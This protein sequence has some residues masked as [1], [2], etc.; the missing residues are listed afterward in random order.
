M[1]ICTTNFA[2]SAAVFAVALVCS[3]SATIAAE[4]GSLKGKFVYDGK[5][6]SESLVVTKDPE[7]CGKHELKD[8]TI[9]LGEN[10]ELQNAYVFLYVAPGKKVDIHPDYTKEEAKPRVLDNKG[11]RFEPHAM[12]LWTEHPLEI[13]N[14]DQGIG[15][16]TNASALRANRAFNDSV[17]NSDPLVKKFTK[18]EPLPSPVAC[19][20]HPWMKAT[21]LIR[22]NP[23]MA[24][25]GEDGSFEIKNVPAGK[26]EFVFW[27]EGGG[28]MRNLKAGDGKT[29][30]KG[31]LKVTIAPGK[32]VDLGEIKVAPETLG[33]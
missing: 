12:A 21:I 27:H 17:S 3:S 31:D 15:H 18:S 26:H 1:R 25:S 2:T 29:G 23:Y 30:R 6:E 16:N 10:N 14:S 33:Q 28:Y 32:T 8:E 9:V 4:W 20:I 5:H 11:C 19:S 22:E 24:V 7:F 13:R